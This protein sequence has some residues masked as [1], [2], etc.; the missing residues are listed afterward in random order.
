MSSTNASPLVSAP[1]VPRK[2]GRPPKWLAPADGEPIPDVVKRAMA[3]RVT[4]Q[5]YFEAH[6]EEVLVRV[7]QNYHAR[8][9]RYREALA[10]MKALPATAAT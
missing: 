9:A 4:Q 3:S 1:S 10:A 2:A 6:R 8:M 5:R 7:R